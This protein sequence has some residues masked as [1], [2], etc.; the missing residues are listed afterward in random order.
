[1]SNTT[2]ESN[3]PKCSSSHTSF[4]KED[5]FELK[6]GAGYTVYEHPYST[7]NRTIPS[8]SSDINAAPFPNSAVVGE[9]E[10]KVREAER[11]VA[12]KDEEISRLK[13]E[14][15]DLEQDLRVVVK[16]ERALARSKGNRFICIIY[17]YVWCH[18]QW[19]FGKEA[20]LGRELSL[21][22]SWPSWITFVAKSSG[23]VIMFESVEAGFWLELVFE[24]CA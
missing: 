15:A 23:C 17:I 6:V 9:L 21:W 5:N 4:T 1:M 24:Y 19:S 2:D 11:R 18:M 16:E 3:D 10:A 12:A 14:V 13:A 7:I 20:S 8:G 22:K